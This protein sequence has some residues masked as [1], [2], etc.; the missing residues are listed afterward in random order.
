LLGKTIRRK[1]I[2]KKY[3]LDSSLVSYIDNLGMGVE[4]RGALGGTVYYV[5]NNAGNDASLGKEKHN[6]LLR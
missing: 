5:E 2:I 1:I 3:N 6:L 4:N